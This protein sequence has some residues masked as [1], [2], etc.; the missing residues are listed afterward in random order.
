MEN[1]A[2]LGNKEDTKKHKTQSLN[3][4]AKTLETPPPRTHTFSL[5]YLANLNQEQNGGCGCTV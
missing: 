4:K 2:V 3:M 1:S 5:L